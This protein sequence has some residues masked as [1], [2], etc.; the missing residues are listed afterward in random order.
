MCKPPHNFSSVTN[1]RK[2]MNT[3]FQINSTV[4]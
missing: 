4:Q 3:F 2:A 1:S